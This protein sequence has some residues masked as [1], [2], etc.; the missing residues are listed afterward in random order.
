[1]ARLFGNPADAVS[2]AAELLSD[3]IVN[4]IGAPIHTPQRA[5]QQYQDVVTGQVYLYWA[6]TW[7]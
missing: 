6:G 3:P 2:T 1:M 5:V 4:G 7:H